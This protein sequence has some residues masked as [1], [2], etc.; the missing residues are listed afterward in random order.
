MKFNRFLNGVLLVLGCLLLASVS[1]IVVLW[2]HTGE[3]QLYLD[4]L[5]GK[6]SY[7]EVVKTLTQD[8][9]GGVFS[10]KIVPQEGPAISPATIKFTYENHTYK[11][12]GIV[13][14]RVYAGAL[15]ARRSYVATFYKS[16]TQKRAEYMKA[17]VDDPS[18][19]EA[20]AALCEGFR[21]IKK[22]RGFSSDEYAEFITKYVQSIPYDTERASAGLNNITLKGDPRFPV[23]VIVD[24]KG[25]CDEKVYLLAALLK[26][27]G[28]GCAGLLFTSEKHMSLGIKSQ[29]AGYKGSGYEFVETTGPKYLSEV[30]TKFDD[31]ITLESTP[32][33]IVFGDGEHY[34]SAQA[35][36]EVSYIVAAR[37]SAIAASP[38][39]KQLAEEAQS[40]AVFDR[41]KTMYED[42]FEAFNSLQ[43]TVDKN[44][45][46]IE[47]FKDR[48]EA[49]EWLGGHAWWV[50]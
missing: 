36:D 13:D 5:Q 49:I 16:E 27:E 19:Q 14:P 35:V 3:G 25:D 29:G 22:K 39:A 9:N 20:I 44:G 12:K 31:G 8:A 28:Y 38:R 2:A 42:C 41:Y 4:A 40:K 6:A 1:A 7:E 24:G 43:S 26:H 37:D 33:V 15:N 11:V 10:L 34:Y 46:H 32:E 45:K 23:Q 30:V 18:Q 48:V 50:K 47:E 21:T 17:L